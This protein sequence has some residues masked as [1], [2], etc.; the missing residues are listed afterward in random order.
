MASSSPAKV[1][2]STNVAMLEVSDD[3]SS[4]EESFREIVTSEAETF[5]TSDEE[6]AERLEMILES[7][8]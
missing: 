8:I 1:S 4:S 3:D 7:C 5:S 2:F 6:D